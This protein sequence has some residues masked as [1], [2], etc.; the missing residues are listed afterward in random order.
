MIRKSHRDVG[1]LRAERCVSLM[2]NIR[3]YR[4]SLGLYTFCKLLLLG[5]QQDSAS[6]TMFSNQ[7]ENTVWL[8]ALHAIL[9]P[10]VYDTATE[11]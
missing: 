3:K 11:V 1:E 8:R 10:M 6:K 2:L 9:N 4:L 7:A 5:G